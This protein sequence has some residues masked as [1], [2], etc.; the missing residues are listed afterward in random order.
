MINILSGTSES[1]F[2]FKEWLKT[3]RTSVYRVKNDIFGGYWA[4]KPSPVKQVE[5]PDDDDDE[6][7]MEEPSPPITPVAISQWPLAAV[8]TSSTT[9]AAATLANVLSRTQQPAAQMSAAAAAMMADL[10]A[11]VNQAI[12]QLVAAADLTTNAVRERLHNSHALVSRLLPSSVL[13]KYVY[14]RILEGMEIRRKGLKEWYMD[15]RISEKG[16]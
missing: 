10:P 2:D 7:S 9:A 16:E 11:T 15:G 5:V 8:V 6:E 12:N 14:A 1:S 3:V 13:Q 4:P